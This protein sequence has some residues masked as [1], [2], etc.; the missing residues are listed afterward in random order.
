[1]WLNSPTIQDKN[2]QVF[3]LKK[4]INPGAYGWRHKHWLES[5]YPEDLP[6]NGSEDWRLSYYSNEF[7]TVMVPCDYWK[8]GES[9]DCV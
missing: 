3:S 2:K 7:N 5:F 1:M 9:I 8:S 6:V 4:T